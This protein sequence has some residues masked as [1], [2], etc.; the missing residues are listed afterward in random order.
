[1][2]DHLGGAIMGPSRVHILAALPEAEQVQAWRG[3]GLR[4][5]W[6]NGSLDKLHM[7]NEEVGK[8][9]FDA[10]NARAEPH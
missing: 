5:H 10:D 3:S 9:T 1:M 7:N 2:C 8:K 6:A 4:V